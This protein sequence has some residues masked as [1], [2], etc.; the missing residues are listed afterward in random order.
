M[1]SCC[2]PGRKRTAKAAVAAPKFAV[3]AAAGSTAGMALIPAGDF[4]MGTDGTYG[5]SADGEGPAHAVRL[6]AFFMGV[7]C[8]TNE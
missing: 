8:V 5:F 2:A 1:D 7:T 6:S 4:L 3:S